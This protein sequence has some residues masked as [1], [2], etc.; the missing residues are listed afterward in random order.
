MCFIF[1]LKMKK[2]VSSFKTMNKHTVEK[3]F[4]ENLKGED[5][6]DQIFVLAKKKL[7]NTG[8]SN[9]QISKRASQLARVM[10]QLYKQRKLYNRENVKRSVIRNIETQI[11]ICNERRLWH[12]LA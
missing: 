1:Q 3:P 12:D 6:S 9:E 10:V 7:Q 11:V 4:D 8:L 2:C 5:L